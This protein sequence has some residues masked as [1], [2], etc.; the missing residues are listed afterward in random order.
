MVNE[1]LPALAGVYSYLCRECG[2]DAAVVAVKSRGIAGKTAKPREGRSL[3][4]L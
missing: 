3:P 2:D 1:T 4:L